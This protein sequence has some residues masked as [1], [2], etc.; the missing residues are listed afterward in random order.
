MTTHE[1]TRDIVESVFTEKGFGKSRTLSALNISGFTSHRAEQ[2]VH[3]RPLTIL[4]GANSSGK[5]SAIKPLLLLKQTLD[6][7]F[8]PGP[9][10]INGP[11]VA[12]SSYDQMFTRYTNEET[13]P[14]FTISMS[15]DDAKIT[16]TF[17]Q[18]T[19]Q[20][21]DVGSTKYEYFLDSSRRGLAVHLNLDPKM[22]SED[23]E[24]Q[25]PNVIRHRASLAA[26]SFRSSAEG[27]FSELTSTLLQRLSDHP[28][29]S[30]AAKS[31][32]LLTFESE[33]RDD[34]WG[35]E[36]NR[37]F[38][39]ASLSKFALELFALEPATH[40]ANNFVEAIRSTIHIPA[41]RKSSLRSQP[42][43][44]FDEHFQGTFDH[45]TASV[46]A[47]WESDGDTRMQRLIRSLRDLNLTSNISARRVSDAAVEV[48]IAR[49]GVKG[50]SSS[51]DLVSL[52]DVGAGVSCVLPILVALEVAMAGQ[53][54]YAEQPE[55]HLHPRAQY[56]LARALAR[57][58]NRGVRV[59][60]ETHSSLL[61]LHIQTLVGRGELQPEDVALHWFSLDRD[62]FSSIKCVH[63]DRHGRTGDW[64]EDFADT[65]MDASSAFLR[66]T[67]DR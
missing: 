2:R 12:F 43:A 29:F 26:D 63:P 31:D 40:P 28:G 6:S 4:S 60:V 50:K 55:T 9:L 1:S 23:I 48:R 42:L 10:L 32:L 61:L 66:A 7:P 33:L 14:A 8:D 25:L 58:A 21:I 22:N 34:S 5:S 44:D 39:K 24:R 35:V 36:R 65:E 62:G 59:I 18:T 45:Y 19:D 37:C 67:R 52:A 49:P 20:T 3:I 11:N 38:L 17:R 15:I 16:S 30:E 41:I 46:V 51:S 54:V 57:A 53:I 27:G 13:A 47:K 56:G 64:P